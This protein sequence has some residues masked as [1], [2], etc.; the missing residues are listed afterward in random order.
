M[1]EDISPPVHRKR[2]AAPGKGKALVEVIAAVR[3][4]SSRPSFGRTHSASRAIASSASGAAAHRTAEGP[5]LTE[6]GKPTLGIESGK[7]FP[8]RMAGCNSPND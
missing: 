3:C 7:N 4:L 5:V 6:I 8:A 2:C 1:C